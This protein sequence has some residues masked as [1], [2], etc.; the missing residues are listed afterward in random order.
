MMS[1]IA[2]FVPVLLLT[3]CGP[4]STPPR[5]AEAVVIPR[6]EEVRRAAAPRAVAESGGDGDRA[7][8]LD[9]G[10]RGEGSGR[11]GRAASKTKIESEGDRAFPSDDAGTALRVARSGLGSCNDSN[12]A[13]SFDVALRFEPSGRVGEV[14]VVPSRDDPARSTEHDDV[15]RCVQRRLSE[16]SVRSFAGAPVTLR[17]TVDL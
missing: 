12:A 9:R 17:M 8:R 16:V 1:R 5:P 7:A 11:D 13:R 10:G 3:A 14:D 4:A 15:A 2:A 6:A